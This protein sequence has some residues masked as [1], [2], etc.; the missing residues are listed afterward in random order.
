[1]VSFGV[2]YGDRLGWWGGRA[3]IPSAN[4]RGHDYAEEGLLLK[5]DHP[6]PTHLQVPRL[7]AFSL[8]EFWTSISSFG[9]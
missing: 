8:K 5:V 9:F 7:L 2:S 6:P 4:G 3:Q 1:M